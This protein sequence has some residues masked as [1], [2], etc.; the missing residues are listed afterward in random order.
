MNLF[1]SPFE[2]L[3]ELEIL[4]QKNNVYSV[5]SQD[6]C[7]C[8]CFSYLDISLQ[9]GYYAENPLGMGS[10]RAWSSACHL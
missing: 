1:S 5:I 8:L 4:M 3:L 6:F 9:E 2:I 7:V 10:K